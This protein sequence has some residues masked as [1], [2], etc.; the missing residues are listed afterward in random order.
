MG[1]FAC[2]LLMCVT[3]CHR[4]HKEKLQDS[5]ARRRVSRPS[6]H[7]QRPRAGNRDSDLSCG[8]AGGGGGRRRRRR[9]L[10]SMSG[11]SGGHLGKLVVL[12]HPGTGWPHCMISAQCSLAAVESSS[13][14]VHSWLIRSSSSMSGET[15]WTL[16]WSDAYHLRLVLRVCRCQDDGHIIVMAWPQSQP[17]HAWGCIAY[18]LIAHIAF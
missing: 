2:E 3:H 5:S 4:T 16:R 18:L 6:E 1:G 7:A 9:R 8:S 14:V 17:T 11:V 10:S 15:F 12:C 13:S